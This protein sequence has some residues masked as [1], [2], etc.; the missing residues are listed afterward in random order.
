M[1]RRHFYFYCYVIMH[2]CDAITKQTKKFLRTLKQWFLNWVRS[3]VRSNPRVSVRLQQ[4]FGQDQSRISLRKYTKRY[5]VVINQ[6][7]CVP[8]GKSMLSIGGGGDLAKL[9]F[10]RYW[11]MYIGS[12]GEFSTSMKNIGGMLLDYWGDTSPTPLDLHPCCVQFMCC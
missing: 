11:G 1:S 3:I 2:L 7:F 4:G 6:Y 10:F 12:Y 8:G 9:T 5:K